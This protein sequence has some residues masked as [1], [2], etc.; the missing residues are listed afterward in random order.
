MVRMSSV[1]VPDPGEKIRLGA[2]IIAT[3]HAD[4]GRRDQSQDRGGCLGPFVSHGS[5]LLT[6]CVRDSAF[7]AGAEARASTSSKPA[8]RHS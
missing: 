7:R 6:P 5:T 4:A 3:P 1:S 8:R 2:T